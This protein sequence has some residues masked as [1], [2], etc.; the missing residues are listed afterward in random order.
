M[1]QGRFIVM[2]TK[3]KLTLTHSEPKTRINY[4]YY[5]DTYGA[6]SSS[7]GRQCYTLSLA[8]N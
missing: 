5:E 1:T 7:K 2:T 6:V 3:E 4:L 8:S